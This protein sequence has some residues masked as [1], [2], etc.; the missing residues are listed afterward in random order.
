MLD[1]GK[2]RQ[3]PRTSVTQEKQNK[4]QRTHTFI[5]RL[6]RDETIECLKAQKGLKKRS[7][8]EETFRIQKEG[9]DFRLFLSHLQLSAVKQVGGELQKKVMRA[10][11][12]T[13][14]RIVRVFRRDA[15]IRFLSA[16]CHCSCLERG[17]EPFSSLRQSLAVWRHLH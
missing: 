14:A 16:L 10:V 7:K 17:N 13:K 3:K 9:K 5:W 2:E 6:T 12:S 15:K 4:K 11:V 1:G 8:G